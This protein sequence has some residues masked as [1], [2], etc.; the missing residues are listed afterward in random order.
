MAYTYFKNKIYFHVM[1]QLF[2]TLLTSRKKTCFP[3]IFGRRYFQP[4]FRLFAQKFAE[5][6]VSLESNWFLLFILLFLFSRLS[7]QVLKIWYISVWFRMF[8]VW[9]RSRTVNWLQQLIGKYCLL[10]QKNGF[11]IVN[12]VSKTLVYTIKVTNWLKLIEPIYLVMKLIESKYTKC[13]MRFSNRFK[14]R[15]FFFFFKFFLALHV[16]SHLKHGYIKCNGHTCT[17]HTPMILTSF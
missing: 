8:V 11:I 6:S 7:T 2:N 12:V 10:K 3:N 9:N 5:I 16:C 13:S 17:M 4:F 15:R 1:C 14:V